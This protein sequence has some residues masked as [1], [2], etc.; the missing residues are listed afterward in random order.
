MELTLRKNQIESLRENKKKLK[1]KLNQLEVE[2]REIKNNR[3]IN[4]MGHF[5][6]TQNIS[7][8]HT[9]KQLKHPKLKPIKLR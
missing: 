4:K 9:L 6:N 1:I 3:A 5:E 2:L 7:K 8:I